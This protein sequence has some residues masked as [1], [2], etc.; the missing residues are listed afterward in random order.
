MHFRRWRRSSASRSMWTYDKSGNREVRDGLDEL[1]AAFV[2]AAVPMELG[3]SDA[4]ALHRLAHF[5]NV[6]VFA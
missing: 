6:V 5:G 3:F 2:A 4:Q 1:A